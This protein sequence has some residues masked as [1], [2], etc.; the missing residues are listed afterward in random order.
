M[1]KVAGVNILNL[2]KPSPLPPADNRSPK[3]QAMDRSREA[4]AAAKAEHAERERRW[5]YNQT[6]TD[7]IDSKYR[8]TRNPPLVNDLDHILEQITPEDASLDF[9]AVV[10]DDNEPVP[11]PPALLPKTKLEWIHEAIAVVRVRVERDM[12]L[13]SLADEERAMH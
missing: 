5:A 4:V 6:V 8:T 9:N 11:V 1:G 13:K 7:V 3:Q 12:L 10:G 2:A